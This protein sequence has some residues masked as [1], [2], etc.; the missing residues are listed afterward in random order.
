MEQHATAVVKNMRVR[1]PECLNYM[2]VEGTKPGT[3]KGVCPVCKACVFSRQ[4]NQRERY[5]K[6]VRHSSVI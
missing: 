2:T 6:I 3:Y 5:L 4:H 1:C